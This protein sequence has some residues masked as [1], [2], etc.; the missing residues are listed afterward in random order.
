MIRFIAT[1]SVCRMGYNL[2]IIIITGSNSRLNKLND[3][4]SNYMFTIHC[5]CWLSGVFPLY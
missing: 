3:F 2:G 1:E 5:M 4:C